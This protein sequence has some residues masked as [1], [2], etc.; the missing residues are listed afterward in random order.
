[1]TFVFIVGISL[2][3]TATISTSRENFV[4]VYEEQELD[5]ERLE[6]CSEAATYLMDSYLEKGMRPQRAHRKTSK[7]FM[8]CMG[9]K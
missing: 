7:F 6:T 4:Q 1:M 2:S 5:L 9:I 8:D 3:T